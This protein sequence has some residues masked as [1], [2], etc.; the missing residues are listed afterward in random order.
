MNTVAER[1]EYP[2]DLELKFIRTINA[3]RAR[4]WQ[5]WADI[6]QVSKWWGPVGFS[7]TT[8]ER[9]FKTGGEWRFLM[10]GPD[11]TDYSNRI[12][13]HEVNEGLRLVY[14]HGSETD[15]LMFYVI[16]DFIVCGSSTRIETV[17]K[18]RS[19]EERDTTATYGI[20][21]HASTMGRLEALLA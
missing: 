4:V 18:F 1:V 21:G 13:Y 15:P 8:H 16:T 2:S 19:K 17:M 11:G 5:A 14:D 3:S 20:P 7:I 10:H 9:Q 6:E 12:A